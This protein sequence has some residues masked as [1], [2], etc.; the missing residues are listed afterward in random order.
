MLLGQVVVPAAAPAVRRV[1]WVPAR[2]S[3]AAER[4]WVAPAV[5]VAP[6]S[7]VRGRQLGVQRAVG[8]PRVA[9]AVQVRVLVQLSV[10]P[11]RLVLLPAPARASRPL[12]PPLAAARR[13]LARRSVVVAPEALWRVAPVPAAPQG[14]LGVPQPLAR[15]CVVVVLPP[16]WPEPARRLAAAWVLLVQARGWEPMRERKPKP[17]TRVVAAVAVP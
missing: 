2:P 1:W 3:A 10:G 9:V 7:P 16:E 6:A 15:L 8:R 17:I 14:L 4:P 5:A 13:M 12:V 11:V